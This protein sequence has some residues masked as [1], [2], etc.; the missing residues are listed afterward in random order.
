MVVA[1]VLPVLALSGWAI[2]GLALL[3]TGSVP[4]TEVTLSAPRAEQ[5]VQRIGTAQPRRLP[6]QRAR[7]VPEVTT[8]ATS[9]PLPSA[10]AS[11]GG[12]GRP[13]QNLALA[14][15]PADESVSADDEAQ[16]A[17]ATPSAEPH[18]A[19]ESPAGD[20]DGAEPAHGGAMPASGPS[21]SAGPRPARPEASGPASAGPAHGD[22]TGRPHTAEPHTRQPHTG[23]PR[24]EP[25]ATPTGDER[26][27][28]SG[29]ARGPLTPSASRPRPCGGTL[30][31]LLACPDLPVSLRLP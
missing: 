26:T 3:S 10:P 11:A 4:P 19:P 30:Q 22:P 18:S 15:A 24:T 21:P 23:R 9:T 16:E 20:A 1:S 31:K 14:H 2:V 5:T 8:A 12:G 29:A 25:T 27:R 17:A 28:A 6:G 7:T 13:E